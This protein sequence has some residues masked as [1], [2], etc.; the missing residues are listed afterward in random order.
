MAAGPVAMTPPPSAQGVPVGTSTPAASPAPAQPN[1]S[2]DRNK[3]LLRQATSNLMLLA[4]AVPTVT[5]IL[6]QVL[7]LLADMG[8][9][10][11]QEEATPEPAA[12]PQG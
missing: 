3:S 6:Q 11:M 2:G 4:K 5:P 8:S 1:P 12:P 7:P 9:A 10:L